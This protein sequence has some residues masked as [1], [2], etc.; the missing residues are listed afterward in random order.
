[1]LGSDKTDINSNGRA[2]SAMLL[3]LSADRSRGALL[4]VPA[5]IPV[6]I[7]ACSA[8]DGTRT[9]PQK[10]PF[11]LAFQ[12][13]GAACSIRT[14]EKLSGVRVDHY[15]VADACGFEKMVDAIHGVDL[16]V[17]ER[18]YDP[19]TDIA[20]EP[21]RQKLNGAQALVYARTRQGVGDG[22]E[23]NRM[24]RQQYF[25]K[26]LVDSIVDTATARPDRVYRML[27]AATGALTVDPGLD[28]LSKLYR[29]WDD[30]QGIS[31]AH[32]QYRVLP[33]LN[34]ELVQ[35]KANDLFGQLRDDKELSL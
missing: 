22:T 2:K 29:L 32:T 19:E 31:S 20:L 26:V 13:G 25:M 23:L 9:R 8:A 28:S 24:R 11:N 7:P 35:P 4:S 5:D 30:V 18:I 34:S 12:V 10:A 17:D 33:E 3:H 27:D 15:V 1:M 21:G 16:Q 6:D 14:F